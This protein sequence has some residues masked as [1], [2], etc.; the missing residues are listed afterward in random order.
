MRDIRKTLIWTVALL[1]AVL[2]GDR[3]LSVVLDQVVQRSHFRFSEI[4]RPGIDADIVIV[5]DSRGVSSINVP[6]V[7]KIA[8]RRTYSLCYNGMATKIG[9]ALLADY[10][11]H[12]R[13][14]R[15]LVVEVT[16]LVEPMKL[17]P[18]LKTYAKLSPRLGAL[19]AEEHPVAARAGRVFH[20]LRFNGELYL[21]A[22]Y[23]LRRSDQDWSNWSTISQADVQGARAAPEWRLDPTPENLDSLERIVRLARSRHIEVRLLV[24]PYLPEYLQ[25]AV[26]AGPFI[27]A[28]EERVHRV[29]PSLHV[30]NYAGAVGEPRLFA[31]VLHLN[32]R[33]TDAFMRMLQHDG[34][35]A[36]T[37][38]HASLRT[39]R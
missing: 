6:V 2:A 17:S 34:F 9:E 28:V 39:P 1:L 35:F 10:L 18:E 12:N 36:E 3:L 23:Y 5:G 24:G 8:G 19:Y 21:R 30:W 29:D 27:A 25:R 26:N 37:A 16:S 33:G 31:D 4:Q 20:L 7:E 11:D 15:L 32:N 38:Q 13:P 22:L 14:P